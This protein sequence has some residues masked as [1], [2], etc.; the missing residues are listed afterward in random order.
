LRGEG[1]LVRT[2]PFAYRIRSDVSAV[3]DGLGTLYGGY[4]AAAVDA[5]VDFEVDVS[6]PRGLRRFVRPQARFRFDGSQSFEPLPMAHGFALL[7][8]AMNWCIST[9]VN[10]HLL[11]H[12]AVVERGGRAMVLPAPPGSGKSTLCA[13]LVHRGW[14]LLSDELAVVP[15]A[16]EGLLPIVRPVSL[17]NRSIDII[18]AFEPAARFSRPALGT[19][20]GT[21]AHMQAPPA[22]VARMD[23]AAPPAWIVF[24]R[25]R[26]G[27]PAALTP[28]SKAETL[29]ELARN[30]FNAPTLGLSGFDRLA[31]LVDTCDCHDFEYGRLDDAI[32]CFEA[33]AG[34]GS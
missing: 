9:H 13:A 2:G 1:W 3:I 30:S 25:W 10:H 14:R 20:K 28:R 15:L 11:I 23:E 33:L 17:K 8:W 32:A 19:S 24:P 16:E 29:V 26:A 6:R 34:G 5:F 7:E 12:S 18:A 21:V 27:A 31:R 4:P 22:H